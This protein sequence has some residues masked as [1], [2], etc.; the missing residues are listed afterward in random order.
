MM[1]DPT[2]NALRFT[3]GNR[4]Y[5][6][7]ARTYIMG[8]LNVTP[9]SFSDGGKFLDPRD[10]VDH[11]LR[12]A[13]EGVDI[14]DVGG[15]STRPKGTAYG[16]GA[17]TVPVEDEL[18]RVI[19]VIEA[20]VRQ[21]DVPISIDTYKSGVAR[22]ALRAGAVLVNDISG[23]RF[24]DAMPH[25]IAEAG[26]SA[27]VMHIQGTPQTMQMNPGYTDV[28]GEVRAS[29]AESVRKGHE[30]GIAQIIVDPG[31]G[32]GKNLEHNLSLLRNLSA[33]RVLGCPVLVGPSRKS[34]LSKILNLSIDEREEGTLAAVAASIQN[35]AHIVRVHN[36]RDAVRVARVA[37]AIC[38]TEAIHS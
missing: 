38:R 17:T 11:A 15:E 13:E 25:V 8:I 16:E 14:I 10:A 32:F 34:F 23:F 28:V 36:V 33:F 4:V 9:D 27:V 21:T 22:E 30:A 12:M 1:Q 18:H 24:D 2:N 7:P 31:I 3:L 20:L 37:D 6:F 5:D 19:P 26:A 29:L 35:G